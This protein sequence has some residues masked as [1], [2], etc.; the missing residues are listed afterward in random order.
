MT[1]KDRLSVG[2]LMAGLAAV[3][4][5]SLGVSDKVGSQ[6]PNPEVLRLQAHFRVVERELLARDVSDLTPEQ[7]TARAHHIQVLHGYA[8]AGVFPKNTHHPGQRVPYFEDRYGTLCAVGY[9]IVESGRRDIVDAVAAKMNNATVLEIAADPELGL[10]LAAWLEKSGLTVEEAQRIQPAY[11]GCCFII[12]DDRI[13]T[14]YAVASG[15]T[16]GVAAINAVLSA[17]SSSS[18]KWH[19]AVGVGSGVTGMVLG[20]TKFDNS[21]DA[22]MLGIVNFAVGAASTLL[23]AFNLLSTVADATALADRDHATFTPTIAFTAQGAPRLGVS[24][25]F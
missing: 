1:P 11:N 4:T 25:R 20:A 9:L 7:R 21:G 12:D 24:V 19:G 10:M 2:L 15:V 5:G 23:G 14:G 17:V 22:Q 3:L 13:S 18:A 16:D 8:E 6:P